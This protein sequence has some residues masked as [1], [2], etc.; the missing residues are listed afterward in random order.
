MV[1]SCEALALISKPEGR[2]LVFLFF[3]SYRQFCVVETFLVHGEE[4]ISFVF[5]L[6]R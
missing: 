5:H 3:C 4:Q 1:S 2:H 6:E